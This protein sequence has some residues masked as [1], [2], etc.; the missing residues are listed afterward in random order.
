MKGGSEAAAVV[1]QRLYQFLRVPLMGLTKASYF[2]PS[3]R[4][5]ILMK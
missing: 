3:S 4:I 1:L 5:N 2:F